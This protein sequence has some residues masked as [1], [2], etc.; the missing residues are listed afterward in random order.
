MTYYV[1]TVLTVDTVVLFWSC[2]MHKL[3]LTGWHYKKAK[4]KGKSDQFTKTINDTTL[5]YLPHWSTLMVSFSA[6]KVANGCNI[7]PYQNSQYEMVKDKIEKIIFEE[8]KKK[9][10]FEESYINRLDVNRDIVFPTIK[11]AKDFIKWAQKHIVVG[12]YQKNTYNDNGDYRRYKSGLVCKI[13]LKNE[14]PTL[15]DEIKKN[16]PPTVRIEVECRKSMKRKLLGT[17]VRGDVLKYP[18]VWQ[19]FFNSTL[20]K[21]KLGG[22]ILNFNDYKNTVT[23]ILKLENPTNRQATIDKKVNRLLETSHG[24]N[25]SNRKLMVSLV[26]KISNYNILPYYFKKAE[27]IPDGTLMAPCVISVEEQKL[28]EYNN[29]VNNYVTEKNLKLF[30][31]VLKKKKEAK[32]CKK[33]L[34]KS[35]YLTIVKLLTTFTQKFFTR[36][37]VVDSS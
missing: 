8:T 25:V 37:P 5:I 27:L 34:S 2:N 11:D 16:L 1:P 3:E 4:E 6:S 9:L 19:N 29:Y 33:I 36:V 15:P 30:E 35:I 32:L 23:S 21:F 18:A 13:Y 12:G 26:N 28:I 17:Q 10:H 31:S 14:D 22:T 24:N 20:E 7:F